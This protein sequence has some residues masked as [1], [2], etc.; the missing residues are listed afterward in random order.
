LHYVQ[1]LLVLQAIL[2]ALLEQPVFVCVS[3]CMRTRVCA[4]CVCA[5]DCVYVLVCV[6]VFVCVCV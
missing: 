5:S 6:Y 3:V 2:F 4:A 1:S